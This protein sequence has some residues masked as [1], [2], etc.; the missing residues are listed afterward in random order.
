MS[1][2]QELVPEKR[3]EMIGVKLTPSEHEK[4][5]EYCETKGVSMSRYVRYLIEN[6][7]VSKIDHS[8]Q[9]SPIKDQK[10]LGS[11]VAFAVSALKEW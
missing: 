3:T 6:E 5:Q 7:I 1:K 9:M 10:Q 11:C 2:E 8:L 4:F